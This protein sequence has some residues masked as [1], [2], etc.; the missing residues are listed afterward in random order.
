MSFTVQYRV[1][2][3]YLPTYLGALGYIP[4]LLHAYLPRCAHP[5]PLA[6]WILDMSLQTMVL[7]SLVATTTPVTRTH[8]VTGA[9]SGAC[10][11]RL[12]SAGHGT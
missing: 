8:D 6:I 3:T 5:K 1:L 10:S 2:R 7:I 4:N 11:T 9:L 12:H